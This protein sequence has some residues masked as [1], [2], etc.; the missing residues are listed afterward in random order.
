MLIEPFVAETMRRRIEQEL[1]AIEH[2]HDVRILL[3]IESGSRAWGF[4]SPDSDYD[5]RFIYVHGVEAYLSI[6]S[7]REVIERPVNGVLDINGWDLRKALRLMVQSNTVLFEWLTSPLRYRE[8]EDAP[9]K[10]RAL[11]EETCFLPAFTYHYDRLA[12]RFFEEVT[13]SHDAISFKTYCY[14]LRP[15]LA[16]HWIRH[17]EQPPPMDLPTLLSRNLVSHEVREAI[18]GLVKRKAS[19]PEQATCRRIPILDNFIAGT[20]SETASRSSSPDRV[21]AMADANALF[22]SLVRERR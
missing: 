6:E 21:Q 20:L 10:L 22:A 9:A 13:A 12:R 5:V 14:A 1:H 11:A 15:S 16:L 17:Y 18:S 4:L 8:A 7:R 2:E 3:A 19:A